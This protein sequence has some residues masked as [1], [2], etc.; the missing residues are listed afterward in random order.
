MG[1]SP[2][3]GKESATT[4]HTWCMVKAWGPSWDAPQKGCLGVWEEVCFVHWKSPQKHTKVQTQHPHSWSTPL[5]MHLLLLL[6]MFFSLCLKPPH[7]S[8]PSLNHAS[9]GLPWWSSG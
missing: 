7:S 8:K 5:H 3:G 9:S 1:Y 6:E 4:E 2:W